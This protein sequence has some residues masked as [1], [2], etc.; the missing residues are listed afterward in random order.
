MSDTKELLERARRQFP[1]SGD[2]MDAL[3]RR[4]DRKRRNRRIGSAVVAL[5][6]VGTVA[7]AI[8]LIAALG[9]GHPRIPATP[10][11]SPMTAYHHNGEIAVYGE[12]IPQKGPQCVPLPSEPVPG[13]ACAIAEVDPATGRAVLLPI[14]GIGIWGSGLK[15]T[16][17]TWSPDGSEL[18]YLLDDKVWIFDLSTGA[19]EEIV[20]CARPRG[21][22]CALAWSPDG[23]TIAVTSGA[24]IDLIRPDGANLTSLKPL[25]P[26]GNITSPAWLPDGRRIAFVSRRSGLYEVDRT[27][28]H[29]RHLGDIPK[30]AFAAAFSPDGS[31][32][33]YFELHWGLHGCGSSAKPVCPLTLTVAPTDGSSAG[34]VRAVGSCYCIGDNPGL[35]WSPDGKKLALVIPK[36]GGPFVMNADGTG[37]R[38]IGTKGGWWGNPAWRPVP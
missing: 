16:G 11:P 12:V 25:G 15:P 8:S 31:R 33:A 3:V 38:S 28:A 20:Q 21:P 6:M 9:G 22:G 17:L 23:E 27:G 7:A 18:A 10:T 19:P 26:T 29:L 36:P 1:P 5:V 34:T 24:R 4:R 32:I 35:G 37:L 14:G 2:V 30:G 13:R